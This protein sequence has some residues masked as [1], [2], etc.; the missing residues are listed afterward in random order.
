[1]EQS[2]VPVV[3]ENYIKINPKLQKIILHLDN[4]L[5]GKNA[6]EA[7]RYVLKNRYKVENK[8]SPSGKDFNEYLCQL[9]NQKSIKILIKKGTV[10]CFFSFSPLLFLFF[11]GSYGFIS[12]ALNF[13]QVEN[14]VLASCSAYAVDD[15]A[16]FHHHEGGNAE[17]LKFSRKLGVFI[18]VYLSYEKVLSLCGDLLHQGKNHTAGTAPI[19]IEV[20]KR[21]SLVISNLFKIIIIKSYS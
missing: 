20:K 13:Y 15:H 8:P 7:L 5:A 11:P 17:N 10:D 1:M 12:V 4:D 14:C 9:V 18:Y 19:R 6:T 2:K 21:Y 3:L 16:V